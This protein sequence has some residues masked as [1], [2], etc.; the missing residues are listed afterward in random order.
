M[1][2]RSC[3]EAVIAWIRKH[4]DCLIDSIVAGIGYANSHVR[5]TIARLVNLNVIR[6]LPAIKRDGTNVRR[7]RVYRLRGNANV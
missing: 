2:S 3:E 5:L 6:A 1:A 7:C 4:P